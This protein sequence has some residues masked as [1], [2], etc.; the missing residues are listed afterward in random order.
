[1]AGGLEVLI[2]PDPAALAAAGAERVV[3]ACREAI[4]AHGEFA[5]ALSGGETPKAL[6]ARLAGEPFRRAIPW[7]KVRVFWGD[8]RCVP[9]TDPRSNFRMAQETL[10]AHVPVPPG[11][12]HR[13][14]AERADLDQAARDYAEVLRARLP[15][16]P[17]RWPR[18]DLILLG[19]GEDAHTASLFPEA[20]ALRET[21]RPVVAYRLPSQDMDRMTL[22][23]PVLRRAVEVLFLVSGPKKADALW[24]VLEGPRRPDAVPA[25]LIQP[26][27]GGRVVW[28]A[29]AAAA[30]RLSPRVSPRMQADAG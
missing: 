5:I 15:Q 3:R 28:L 2:V 25:Q 4:A 9:P 7:D 14:P 21:R 10:L 8:E 27:T 26:V 13:M 18:F 19:L 16:T 29:D 1:M 24:Q 11:R 22:T 23:V 20:P 30:S 6:Y 12:V 17:D